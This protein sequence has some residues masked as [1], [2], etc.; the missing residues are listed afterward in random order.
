[1]I[2]GDHLQL[3]YHFWLAGDMISGRTPPFLDL[4]QFNTG[5]DE[6]CFRRSAF[7]MPYSLI[8]TIAAWVG[9]QA[10]GMNLAAFLSLWL[11]TLFTWRLVRRYTEHESTAAAVA[12]LALWFPY[13]WGNLLGGSPAGLA[14]SWIPGLLLGLD[15]W[16]RHGS[17]KG[18]IL[19]GLALLFAA[20]GDAHVLFFGVLIAPCWCVLVALTT[21]GI[22]SEW[23]QAARQ[24]IV[25]LWPATLGLIAAGLYRLWKLQAIAESAAKVR[26][27]TEVLLYSPTWQGMFWSNAPSLSRRIYIGWI[28]T[29]WILGGALILLLRRPRRVRSRSLTTLFLL[30]LGTVL[31][32]VLALGI[33]GPGHGLL[34][35]LVRQIIP[36]YKMIRQ[37]AK[38]FV[39]MPSLLAVGAGIALG[40]WASLFPKPWW[41]YACLCLFTVSIAADYRKQVATSICLL[42]TKQEAYAAVAEDAASRGEVP[43]ALAV[44]LWPGDSHWSSLYQHYASLYRVRMLNGY[45]PTATRDYFDKVFRGFDSVNKGQ[46]SD[47][48]LAA[49]HGMGLHYIVLHENAFPEKVSPFPVGLTL[50]RLL[51]HTRLQLLAQSG[52][53]WAFRILPSPEARTEVASDWQTFFPTRRWE[54]EGCPTSGGRRASDPSAGNG[55]FLLVDTAGASVVTA[56]RP[57]PPRT[58]HA[59]DMRWLLR[60]RGQGQLTAESVVGNRTNRVERLDLDTP[61]WTWF[62]VAT[63]AFPGQERV[64]LRLRLAQGRAELDTAILVAGKWPRLGIGESFE[65]P[66]PCFFHAGYTELASNRV[67]MRPDRDFAG[68]VFYGPRLPLEPGSYRIDFR[69]SSP[70]PAGTELGTFDVTVPGGPAA[71]TSVVVGR[72]ARLDVDVRVNLPIRV[73]FVYSRDAPIVIGSVVFSRQG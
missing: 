8:Y 64:K 35:R 59:P 61:K 18:S 15:T 58:D 57:N 30:I 54:L 45:S 49:L 56:R 53:V 17:L 51:N 65:V 5:R 36:P 20:W 34:P 3:L 26:S 55:S 39:L 31:V 72:A 12:L 19:T 13:R 40:G 37:P 68:R 11:G 69:F 42:D 7:F 46:L 50:K 67:I 66:A 14:M 48:Q 25:A 22:A 10:F 60:A 23:H 4:Y 9:G 73:S 27:L 29:A 16:V 47:R 63:G 6:D 32:V 33:R 52:E 38:I 2:A 62:D 43:R 28:L 41:R 21:P 24:R 44:P 71:G 70:A 1:M